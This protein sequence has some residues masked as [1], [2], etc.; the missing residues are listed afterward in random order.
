MMGFE[1]WAGRSEM[2]AWQA[3]VEIF[4]LTRSIRPGEG[5]WLRAAGVLGGAK[6][7][8]GSS[9]VS[10]LSI[11]LFDQTIIPPSRPRDAASAARRR[12]Q[13]SRNATACGAE[14]VLDGGE[15]GARLV[16]HG[17]VFHPPTSG[18]APL[19]ACGRA[20]LW[21]SSCRHARRSSS[22]NSSKPKPSPAW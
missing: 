2:R 21:P 4:G 6:G 17:T 15:H 1:G 20:R 3:R 11:P 9:F 18:E 8:K 14:G 22:P 16:A 12:S 19:R 5:R 13:G 10:L 7:F